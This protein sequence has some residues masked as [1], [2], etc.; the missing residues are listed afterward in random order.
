MKRPAAVEQ[1][2]GL[3]GALPTAAVYPFAGPEGEVARAPIWLAQARGR[4]ALVAEAG[5]RR[6]RFEVSAAEDAAL[7]RGLT[8]DRVRVGPYTL[9]LERKTGDA[10]AALVGAF[11]ATADGAPWTPPARA[12]GATLEAALGVP[13]WW[14]EVVGGAPDDPWVFAVETATG[15]PMLAYDGRVRRA[16]VLVGLSER[17]LAVA[18]RLEPSVWTV[19]RAPGALART[20]EGVAVGPWRLKLKARLAERLLGLA[21]LEGAARVAALV[22]IAL[23]AGL[24]R[25]A[26]GAIG[27]LEQLGRIEVAAEALSTIAWAAGDPARALRSLV[28]A[29]VLPPL[30]QLSRDLRRVEAGLKKAPSGPREALIGAAQ[31]LVD[32]ILGLEGEPLVPPDAPWPAASL[33]ELLALARA[34]RGDLEGARRILTSVPEP[35]RAH[36][37]VAIAGGPAEAWADAAH[38]YADADDLSTARRLIS[39]A[40]EAEPTAER[41]ALAAVWA[42]R[43]GDAEACKV[44]FVRA[45]KA[46]LSTAGLVPPPDSTPSAR[47]P[48]WTRWLT[49]AGGPPWPRAA[50]PAERADAVENVPAPDGLGAEALSALVA[51]DLDVELTGILAE[52]AAAHARPELA[53]QLLFLAA[54]ARG[55]DPAR[56]TDTAARLADALGAPRLAAVLYEAVAARL[57]EDEGGEPTRAWLDAARARAADG[58]ERGAQ[59]DLRRAI[60]A[61]FLHP[62]TYRRALEIG[63]SALPEDLRQWWGHVMATLREGSTAAAPGRPPVRAIEAEALDALHPGG[64]GWLDRVKTKVQTAQPPARATL[65]RGL[66]R[67]TK[68]SFEAAFQTLDAL[69]AALRIDTPDGFVYRGDDAFGISAWPLEAPVVLVGVEH[70]EPGPRHL[71]PAALRFALAVEL[72]HLAAEHPLLAFESG[73]LGTSQSA[74]QAFG[75]FAGTAETIVDVLSI[76]PGVDQLAKLQKIVALSRKFFVTKNAVDKLGGLASRRLV[77]RPAKAGIGRTNLE[78]T[79][80]QFRLHADRVALALTGDLHAGVEAILQTSQ[81]GLDTLETFRTAGLAAA[82]GA[83]DD[84]SVEDTLR[85]S[86]LVAHAAAYRGDAAPSVGAHFPPKG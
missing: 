7:L 82:L 83:E 37:R 17:G 3:E 10:A 2:E 47:A 80:L 81:R 71:S 70:L 86:S 61:G 51:S 84:L 85:L 60:E 23:D 43:C 33:A 78:G 41:H 31:R 72:A 44:D 64:L 27:R 28:R 55:V 79:A 73:L 8:R 21:A 74:Y 18:A 63:G 58:D 69:S 6:W 30:D 4:L 36:A 62:E 32:P 20:S 65:V 67:L 25:A 50:G 38:G 13:D 39:R 46:G 19:E 42:A 66:E 45:L 9:P 75:R 11:A 35:R 15:Y 12:P 54:C 34:H 5:E 52:L 59:L 49:Q 68:D 56:T 26:M 1:I 57:D 24:P 48:A 76:I 77:G 53:A 22:P 16:P 40:L 29:E 14:A